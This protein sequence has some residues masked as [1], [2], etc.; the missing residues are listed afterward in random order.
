MRWIG[1]ENLAFN[2]DQANAAAA[3]V[4]QWINSPGHYQNLV[5]DNFEQVVLGL[6]FKS[7]GTRM[8][9][10]VDRS[11]DHQRV[12]KAPRSPPRVP[13]TLRVAVEATTAGIHAYVCTTLGVARLELLP[14]LGEFAQ[15]EQATGA[16]ELVVFHRAVTSAREIQAM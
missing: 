4:D 11:Q 2:Y 14:R 12:L 15:E 7:D 8:T 6:Y 13:P 5:T 16:K 9:L 3:C 1:G 10:D